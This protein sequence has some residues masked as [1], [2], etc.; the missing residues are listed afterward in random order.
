MQWI[1]AGHEIYIN[2]E[3]YYRNISDKSPLDQPSEQGCEASRSEEAW[4]QPKEPHSTFSFNLPS[5]TLVQEIW[6]PEKAHNSILEIDCNI[7]WPPK[8]IISFYRHS[9]VNISD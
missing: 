7:A 5:D 2:A 6:I 3:D 1:G 8:D 9:I 4:Q